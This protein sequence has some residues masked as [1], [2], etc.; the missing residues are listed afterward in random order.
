MVAR[1]KTAHGA[2]DSV[3]HAGAFVAVDRRVGTD[4]IAVAAVQVGL[5]HAAGH[6]AHD[7]FVGAGLAKLQCIDDERRRPFAHHGGSDLHEAILKI[8]EAFVNALPSAWI[9][10]LI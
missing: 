5:A 9:R 8:A 2:A 4:E 7:Q 1:R 10:E 3:D 6:D